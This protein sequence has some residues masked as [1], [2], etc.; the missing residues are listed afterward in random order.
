MEACSIVRVQQLQMLYR[1]GAVCPCHNACSARSGTVIAH[2]HRWQ[3]GSHWLGMNSTMAKYQTA[4][5]ERMWQPWSERTSILVASVADGALALSGLNVEYQMGS[6]ILNRLQPVHQS[7]RDAEQQS[8]SNP[9]DRRR[10][11]GPMFCSHLPTLNQQWP[12]SLLQLAQLV[13]SSR[14]DRPQW[15]ELTATVGCRR[16]SLSMT[17]PRSRAVSWTLRHDDRMHTWVTSR[18]ATC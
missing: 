4:T 14:F 5:D 6:G 18:L 1:Q 17:T 13:V 11:P 7:L 8:C 10:M 12:D 16:H 3:D 9:G 15:R 2:E